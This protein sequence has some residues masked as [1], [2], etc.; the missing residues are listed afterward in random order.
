M[1]HSAKSDSAVSPV[2]GTILLVAIAVVLVAVEYKQDV[3]I[4]WLEL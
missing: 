1:Y 2:I 3:K 4:E